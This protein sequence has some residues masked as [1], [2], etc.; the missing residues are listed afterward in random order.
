MSYLTQMLGLTVQNFV[1]AA[2]GMAVL[3]AL[4]PR[5]RAQ[6]Q[7]EHIGN[8]WVDL[9]RAHALHPAAA[10]VRPRARPRLAGRRAERS[11]PTGRSSSA[12]TATG[13]RRT[14]T[15]QAPV[16]AEPDVARALGPGGVADRDQAARHERRR[17][18]QRQLGAPLREPDAA[19]RTSSRS[20]RSSLIPAALCY[21]FGEMVE[22]HAPG[23]GRAR[24][25]DRHLRRRCSRSACRRE[26]AGNPRFA[27]L[28]VDQ[29]ASALAAGRQHGGQGGALRHRQL[30]ALGHRDHGRVERLG[31]R[32]ARLLHAARRPRAAVAHPARRGHLRRRRLGPLRHAHVRHRR[33]LRR[34][35]DGRPHARSTSARR[36][37]PT[38]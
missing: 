26:Q 20:W 4:H 18:L 32:D 1:S 24:G 33:G 10:L 34:R 5:L 6:R 31:Q 23:L 38:R 25:D 30:R 22:R 11:T 3:V 7:S 14:P 27:P 12:T 29:A 2:A 13:R 28:G 17:L 19:R 36:S 16:A 35:A 15:A 21:T 8:F 9:V 37:R